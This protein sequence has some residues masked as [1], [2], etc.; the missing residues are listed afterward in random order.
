MARRRRTRKNSLDKHLKRLLAAGAVALLAVGVLLFVGRH[1]F[2]H[3][4]VVIDSVHYPVV[5]IDVS[6]HNGK[7]DFGKVKDDGVSF[8]FLKASEGRSYVD[9]RFRKNYLKAR[10]SGLVV[11]AYHFF[12]KKTD[13]ELQARN[14]MGA[15]AGLRI[16]LPL[17]VDVEDWGN[18]GFVKNEQTV[19]ELLAMVKCLKRNGHTVMI[20]T[21]GDGYKNYISGHLDDEYLWLC[22][23]KSPERLRSRYAHKIQQY[24][25]WGTV[26]GVNGEVDLNVFNGSRDEWNK[27]LAELGESKR[28]WKSGK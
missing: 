17:V 3:P 12:R 25:H 5:G 23:F 18:D 24:S 7:I 20:Y 27:W 16:D 9:P 2:F 28:V 8:V 14:F 15:V 6:N 19:E 13:G 1:R 4:D 11:G 21:N 26:E 22:S 10:K